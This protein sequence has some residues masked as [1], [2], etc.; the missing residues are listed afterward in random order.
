MTRA[1]EAFTASIA[2]SSGARGAPSNPVPSIALTTT[3]D[4]CSAVP[5]SPAAIRRQLAPPP[6]S[7]SKLA[8]ASALSS[9]GS[10]S[11]RASTSSPASLSSRATTNPSPPLLP[12]PHTMRTGLSDA[13]AVTARATPAPARSISS[14][15]GTPSSWIAHVSRA[16]ISSAVYSGSSQAGSSLIAAMSLSRASPTPR[17]AGPARGAGGAGPRPRGGAPA[18]WLLRAPWRS[19]RPS[20]PDR[21]RVRSAARSP[22]ARAATARPARP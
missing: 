6:A 20:S 9:S 10:V 2:V 16:R 8:R 19:R 12:L 1:P 11:S 4:A 22:G 18:P 17:R 13:I 14:R 3:P 7:R 5:S 21:R 15:E